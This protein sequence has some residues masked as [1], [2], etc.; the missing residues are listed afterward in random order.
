MHVLIKHNIKIH[1]LS[2][3][4]TPEQCQNLHQRGASTSG[5]ESKLPDAHLP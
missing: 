5:L 2:I 1:K 3:I 4:P